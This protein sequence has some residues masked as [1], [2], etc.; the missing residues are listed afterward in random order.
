[1]CVCVFVREFVFFSI[2]KLFA[3]IQTDPNRSDPI[4]T[5]TVPFHTVHT[6]P[7]LNACSFFQSDETNFWFI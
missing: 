7:Y 2:S 4:Q 3:F 1:M 5:N 6:Y